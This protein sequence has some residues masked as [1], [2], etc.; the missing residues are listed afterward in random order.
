MLPFLDKYK[1]EISKLDNVSMDFSPPA[2][3]YTTGNFA[4]NKI[5]SGSFYNGIPQ[6]RVTIFA[7][8]SG[9]LPG[10]EK[11][12]IYKMKT[13]PHPIDIKQES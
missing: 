7:G 5:L 4:V 3:W 13:N 6:S 2:H 11:V 9:C 10:D 1:K 12:S 8:P